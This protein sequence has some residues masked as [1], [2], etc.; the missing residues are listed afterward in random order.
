MKKRIISFFMIL[1]MAVSIVPSFTL[2]VSAKLTAKDDWASGSAKKTVNL[3]PA[4]KEGDPLMLTGRLMILLGKLIIKILTTKLLFAHLMK[5]MIS[6]KRISPAVFI[7]RLNFPMKIRSRLIRA[8][9][10]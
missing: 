9:C 6:E 5:K 4:M 7:G 10:L 8:T 1:C 2:P 3:I